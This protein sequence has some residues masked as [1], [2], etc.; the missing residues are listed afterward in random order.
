MQ[1]V[2]ALEQQFFGV[3]Q[4]ASN[5][6]PIVGGGTQL[7]ASL[8][9][10]GYVAGTSLVLAVQYRFDPAMPWLE[11]SAT[12]NERG[13]KVDGSPA[14][15]WEVGVWF[16]DNLPDNTEARVIVSILSGGLV[17]TATLEF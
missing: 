10:A 4:V 3:G 17:S 11:T 1:T 5:H 13:E 14:A 12:V 8:D 7:K 16:D 2:T 15:F 6:I 9:A